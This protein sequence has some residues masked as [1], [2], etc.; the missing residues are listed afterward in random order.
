MRDTLSGQFTVS[1]VCD[2]LIK[3]VGDRL[4][5]F[6]SLAYFN[7]CK[8]PLNEKYTL[9]NFLDKKAERFWTESIFKLQ[10]LWRKSV[11]QNII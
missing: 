2:N 1:C 6:S 10:E 9:K 11:E 8:I 3:V 4:I 5:F 7:N